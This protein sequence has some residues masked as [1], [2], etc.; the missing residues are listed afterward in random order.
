METI[1][2]TKLIRDVINN[3]TWVNRETKMTLR[4]SNGKDLAINGKNH[5]V[6]SLKSIADKTIIK[7]GYEK[8]YYVD[9]INDF[10]LSLYNQQEQFQ[11]TP[12]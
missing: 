8:S 11:I 2:K 4:F 1:T 5:M 3:S 6:Y 9:F 7:L 12:E 10:T